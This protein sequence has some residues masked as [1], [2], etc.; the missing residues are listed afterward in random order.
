MSMRVEVNSSTYDLERIMNPDKDRQDLTA[1]NQSNCRTIGEYVEQGW[2]LVNRAQQLDERTEPWQSEVREK[3]AGIACKICLN[4]ESV[5]CLC[6]INSLYRRLLTNI[7]TEESGAVREIK[8]SL[9]KLSRRYYQL[10]TPTSEACRQQS[11][12]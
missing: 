5:R 3:K 8:E 7:D 6:R 1:A 2:H 10:L 4:N 11:G 9:E 12:G